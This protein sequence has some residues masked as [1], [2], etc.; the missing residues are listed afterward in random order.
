MATPAPQSV[1]HCLLSTAINLPLCDC[2]EAIALALAVELLTTAKKQKD[3]DL[4]TYWQAM[5]ADDA[6]EFIS[7]LIDKIDSLL[8]E[9]TFKI[10]LKEDAT[11]QIVPCTWVL[12]CKRH[13]L[14]RLIKKYK[15]RLCLQGDLQIDTEEASAPVIA[16]ATIRI[17]LILALLLD[18]ETT[19]I[20]FTNA[21]IQALLKEPVY[22]EFPPG[23]HLIPSLRNRLPPG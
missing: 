20:D 6:A 22:M 15:A 23:S 21:F 18:W 2:Q 10:V 16:W 11:G 17:L 13:A 4:L 8:C 7:A 19:C 14:P 12:C 5:S 9:D 3:P 1:C